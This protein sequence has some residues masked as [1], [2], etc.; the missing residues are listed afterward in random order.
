[1][2]I[3]FIFEYRQKLNSENPNTEQFNKNEERLAD[4][5]NIFVV[6]KNIGKQTVRRPLTKLSESSDRSNIRKSE[7]L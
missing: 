1:M 6:T 2:T 5:N 4:T 3:K 7:D